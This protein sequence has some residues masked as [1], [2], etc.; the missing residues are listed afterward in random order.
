MNKKLSDAQAAVLKDIRRMSRQR[1][2][3]HAADLQHL[4][5]R[6]LNSLERRGFIQ[7]RDARFYPA[8]I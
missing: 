7:Y 5:G 6:T 8:T 1:G 2:F 4:D 3:V